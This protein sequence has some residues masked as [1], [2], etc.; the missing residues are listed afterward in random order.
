MDLVN[1]ESHYE[2]HSD[3]WKTHTRKRMLALLLYVHWKMPE[4]RSKLESFFELWKVVYPL[5]PL[6]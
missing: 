3:N 2:K 6:P 4:K 5:N 1:D